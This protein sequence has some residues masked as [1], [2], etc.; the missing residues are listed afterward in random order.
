MCRRSHHMYLASRYRIHRYP[1]LCCLD[2]ISHVTSYKSQ[3]SAQ[4]LQF[5]DPMASPEMF[6][7]P[8][9]SPCGSPR[10]FGWETHMKAGSYPMVL[11]SKTNRR[12]PNSFVASLLPRWHIRR[13]HLHPAR[14]FAAARTCARAPSFHLIHHITRLAFTARRYALFFYSI[15]G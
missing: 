14:D 4:A 9:A 2:D 1:L 5:I 10:K 7:P 6:A 8:P 3:V 12:H 15:P 11:I 13:L